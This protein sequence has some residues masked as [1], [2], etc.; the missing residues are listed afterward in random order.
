M[1][2]PPQE[3]AWLHSMLV[4]EDGSKVFG[5]QI[6]HADWPRDPYKVSYANGDPIVRSD[7]YA[8]CIDASGETMWELQLA[9]PQADNYFT[10]IGTLPDGRILL[11]FDAEDTSFGPQL[12]VVSRDGLVEEM[13]NHRTLAEA[14][15]PRSLVV[16][17][18]GFLGGDSS[19][20]DMH[21]DRFF[22]PPEHLMFEPCDTHIRRLNFD[23]SLQWELDM[24]SIPDAARNPSMLAME[25]TTLI[26]GQTL[27]NDNASTF[28]TMALLVDDAGGIIWR[29]VYKDAPDAHF[30]RAVPMED[31][32][33]LGGSTYAAKESIPTLRKLTLDGDIAWS[34]DVSD[35]NIQMI[36]Q[37]V[38]LDDGF[39]VLCMRETNNALLCYIDD[40][41]T[42]LGQ[43]AI[44]ASRD[45]EY[46]SLSLEQG[47]DGKLYLSGNVLTW[48]QDGNGPGAYASLGHL[49]TEITSESFE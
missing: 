9:D 5:G 28:E 1:V 31:G 36:R 14:F 17:P 39:A 44:P 47:L 41:G 43:M 33:L 16:T 12:F 24:A 3:G 35:W 27:D 23:L 7:A 21:Y 26:Y 30:W 37:I 46:H 4:W 40:E 13:I 10:P 20:V 38:P 45:A 19:I 8:I 32:Y 22:N 34:L 18:D 11:W 25:D 42:V 15:T 2:T 6:S 48:T 49:F 29:H